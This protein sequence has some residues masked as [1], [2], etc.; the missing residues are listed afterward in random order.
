[1]CG[2]AGQFNYR[3]GA[4]VDEAI[5]GRM[6]ALIAH[7]G[8]DGSGVQSL[9]PVGLAHRRLAIIDLTEAGRQPMASADECVWIT[10]NGEIYNFQEL[11]QQ[12]SADGYR[13]RTR[14]DTEV[15]IAAY[16]KYGP[17]CV[18]QL[19][20]M[21]AFAIWDS[22]LRRLMLARD[23]VGKK[24]LSYW[25]HERGLSFSS[26]PKAF[27]A[28]PLFQRRVDPDAIVAYLALQYVPAPLSAFQDVSKL[29]PAHYALI[30]EGGIRLQRY[31]SLQ[32]A[33]KRHITETEALDE[34]R[35]QLRSAVRNRLMSDVPLGAFLSGG[36]DSSLIVALMAEQGHERV[37]TFSIGFEEAEYNELEHA[38]LVAR[39]YDTEHHEHVVRP[40]ALEVLPD[41][42]WHYNE[43]YADSSAIPTYYLS[44]MTRQHVAV[45]LNGDGG[46]ESF[47]GYE[48]YVANVLAGRLAW[49]PSSVTRVIG[50][51]AR[52]LPG[53]GGGFAARARRFAAV[54][55][56]SREERYI[57]WMCH[58]DRDALPDLCTPEFFQRVTQDPF[59]P[60][61]RTYAANSAEDFVDAT[62]GV[63]V[64]HYL[65]DD[66]LVKVDIA[67]MAFGL[68]ARSP[69]LDHHLME[70]AASLPPALKLRGR[71]KKYLLKK[72]AREYLPDELVARPKMGFGVPLEPWFRNELRELAQDV[73][74]S[75]TMRERGYFNSA[76][77]AALLTDHL[78]GR[79][80]NHYQLWNLL[81]L[82]L[83]HREFID[84]VPP[85]TAALQS[86]RTP[87]GSPASA[88][89]W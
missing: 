64:Q 9:G 5:L 32:Y 39:R 83:W 7:R 55:G 38:K 51:A 40:S 63:D 12:L 44:R 71:T 79:R 8:P 16:L 31:W 52:R 58:F 70:F 33:P 89:T 17:E 22:R 49:I 65:P 87:T 19:D 75:S 21:F 34:L 42:V 82:E 30:D 18:S 57:R 2:I 77:V 20:G 50:R 11:R 47:A 85:R 56:E 61:L 27:L 69:F 37:R 88:G 72:L 15:V 25:T 66:L 24:P 73:L 4:P 53:R 80:S 59:R 81:V 74:L 3:S 84:R 78:S 60:M 41:L 45:A 13:F 76:Y 54:L 86:E 26:E 46:D 23:R 62:L 67:S 29:P 35:Q 48:R 6:C 10:F 28:D 1:M 68:E 43:P 14:T 36:I